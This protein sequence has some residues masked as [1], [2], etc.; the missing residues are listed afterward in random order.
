[1]SRLFFTTHGAS[2]LS[3]HT[4]TV[5][6]TDH[7][8]PKSFIK[9]VAGTAMIFALGKRSDDSMTGKRNISRPFWKM[10]TLLLSLI[11]LKTPV[12]TSNGTILTFWRLARLTTIVRLKRPYL[13]GIC[14][15]HWMPMSAAKSC[16]FITIGFYLISQ[17]VSVRNVLNFYCGCFFCLGSRPYWYSINSFPYLLTVILLKMYVDWHTKRQ[18]HKMHVFKMFITAVCLIFLI[19]T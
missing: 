19:C 9:L 5:L 18:V 1:M 6:S 13:F 15:Q 7:N 16:Y 3:S 17:T 14:S 8:Y 12:T 2:N 4:R 10:I 11:K